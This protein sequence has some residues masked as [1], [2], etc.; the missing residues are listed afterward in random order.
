MHVQDN[1]TK[2]GQVL[3]ESL[4]PALRASLPPTPNRDQIVSAYADRL[5]ALFRSQ[6]FVDRSVE[7]YAR[8]LSDDDVKALAEFYKTPAGQHFN[9]ASPQLATEGA[10]IGQDLARKNIP[11]IL[12]SLC[13]DFP[14]LH[15]AANFCPANKLEKKGQLIGPDPGSSA[16]QAAERVME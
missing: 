10:R 6:E 4:T 13:R 1:E 7:L 15:G 2:L 3:F 16:N 12:R 5:V 14:E 11:D 9:A 8:Y